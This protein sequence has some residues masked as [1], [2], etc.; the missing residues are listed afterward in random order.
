MSYIRLI[1]PHDRN[2][3]GILALFMGRYK[4]NSLNL[5]FDSLFIM[6]RHHST[7]IDNQNMVNF[8]TNRSNMLYMPL[9]Y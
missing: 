9:Q 3:F 4:D 2:R 7:V 1:H 8:N 5:E 6:I